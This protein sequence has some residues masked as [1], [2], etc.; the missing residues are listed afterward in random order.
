MGRQQ[1]LALKMGV[2]NSL[3]RYYTANIP[4]I[5]DL[6]SILLVYKQRTARKSFY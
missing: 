3:T 2:E 1:L 4:K 6:R 5:R